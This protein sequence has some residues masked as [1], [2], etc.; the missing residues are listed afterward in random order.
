MIASLSQAISWAVDQPQWGNLQDTEK[1]I[2]TPS[3]IV[4]SRFN[5]EAPS[6]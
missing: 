1:G 4:N 2:Q 6:S 5:Q 3:S